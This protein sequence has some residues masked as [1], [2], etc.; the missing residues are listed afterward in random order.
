[1]ADPLPDVGNKKRILGDITNQPKASNLKLNLRKGSKNSK[2]ESEHSITLKNSS[3]VS[4]NTSSGIESPKNGNC[5][6]DS[7]LYTTALDE[8]Y[9]FLENKAYQLSVL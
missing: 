1:M 6:D 2:N 8:R 3:P 5:A 7:T 9:E 4:K